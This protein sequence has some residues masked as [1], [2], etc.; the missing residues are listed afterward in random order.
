M[1]GKYTTN[2]TLLDQR[3]I[4]VLM[5]ITPS[6]HSEFIEKLLVQYDYEKKQNKKKQNKNANDDQEIMIP[7]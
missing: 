3:A 4:K 2:I 6:E 5:N 7:R 1:K